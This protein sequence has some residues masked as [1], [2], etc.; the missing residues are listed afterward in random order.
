[1]TLLFLLSFFFWKT[2]LKDLQ[3][4]LPFRQPAEPKR[5][6]LRKLGEAASVIAETPATGELQQAVVP[7]AGEHRAEGVVEEAAASTP[8]RAA[9]PPVQRET[10]E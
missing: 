5:R 4:C 10:E 1:M 9:T 3:S 7:P 6:R 2:L 8:T